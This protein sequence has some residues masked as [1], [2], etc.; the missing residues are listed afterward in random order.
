MSVPAL[1]TEGGK[2]NGDRARTAEWLAGVAKSAPAVR[3][4]S[5][6]TETKIK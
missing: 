3:L 5:F 1:F 2:E 4:A 6:W